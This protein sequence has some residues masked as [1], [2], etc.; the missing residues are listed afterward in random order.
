MKKVFILAE[1]IRINT[2]NIYIELKRPFPKPSTR[3]ND[4]SYIELAIW[5][6]IAEIL[7]KKIEYFQP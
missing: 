5:N 6:R 1:G 7:K 3:Q 2:R 4:L